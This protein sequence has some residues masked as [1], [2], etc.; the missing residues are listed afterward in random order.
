MLVIKVIYRESDGFNRTYLFEAKQPTYFSDAVS[1][2]QE[3]C[4]KVKDFTDNYKTPVTYIMDFPTED[5]FNGT[6]AFPFLC[7]FY[8]NPNN[9]LSLLL[10]R[11]SQI[12]VMSDGKTIDSISC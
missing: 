4:D 11:Q 7:I 1:S 6:T 8:D 10:V 9:E 2:Y 5:D 12:Y 3:W